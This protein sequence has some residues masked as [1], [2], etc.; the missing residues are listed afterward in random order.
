MRTFILLLTVLTISACAVIV[1]PN[2]EQQEAFTPIERTVDRATVRN[3]EITVD[4]VRPRSD[5]VVLPPSVEHVVWYRGGPLATPTPTSVGQRAPTPRTAEPPV[6]AA[7]NSTSIP[8]RRVMDNWP[9]LKE[10]FAY[11]TEYG[12]VDMCNT[13]CPDGGCH[14]G[15][16]PTLSPCEE[17]ERY[18]CFTPKSPPYCVEAP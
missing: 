15:V 13:I 17:P 4:E 12:R 18:E 7:Q 16:H 9:L 14:A 1:D 8:T 5:I 11:E 10:D 6:A 3:G 2:L